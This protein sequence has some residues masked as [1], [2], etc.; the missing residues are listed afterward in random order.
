MINKQMLAVATVVAT[1]VAGTFFYLAKR[2]AAT[3][4]VPVV[5]QPPKPTEVP[6]E[7]AIQHPVPAGAEAA[8]AKAPLPTLVDSDSAFGSALE[9]LIGT[10]AAKDYQI[11]RA[12]V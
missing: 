10:A 9:A 12:H 6:Q 11:G 4:P 5:V 8:A 2:H 1:L 3:P 7:P